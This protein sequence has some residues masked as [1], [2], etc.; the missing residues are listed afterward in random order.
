MNYPTMREEFS[1]VTCFINGEYRETQHFGESREDAVK[2][3]ARS[4][5]A[6]M[7]ASVHSNCDNNPVETWCMGSYFRSYASALAYAGLNPD[8][9]S[10]HPETTAAR[11]SYRIATRLNG[12]G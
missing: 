5:L 8:G 11:R 3:A 2:C 6:P 1:V 10:E 4:S 7:I 9:M 12:R